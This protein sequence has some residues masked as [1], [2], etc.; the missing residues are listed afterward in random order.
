MNN[1]RGLFSV[2]VVVFGLLGSLWI[3][4]TAITDDRNALAQLAGYLAVG[5]FFVGL[6]FGRKALVL[7]LL[8]IAYG[9]LLKRGLV[10]FGSLSYYDIGKVLVTGPLVL[11]GICVN[12]LWA[13]ISGRIETRRFHWLVFIVCGVGAGLSAGYAMTF[14]SSAM[15]GLKNV[16]LGSSYLMLPWV[17]VMTLRTPDQIKRFLRTFLIIFFP[18]ALY[19]IKQ[20]L[21]GLSGFEYEY[22]ESGLTIESRQLVNEVMRVPSTMNAARSLSVTMALCLIIFIILRVCKSKSWSGVL[23]PLTFCVVPVYAL[24]MIFTLT[25]VG[26]VAALLF[27][28]LAV[29]F[30]GKVRTRLTYLFGIVSFGLLVAYSEPILEKW[31]D[32]NRTISGF[33]GADTAFERQA[34]SISTLSARLIGWRNLT[35]DTELWSAFGIK[36]SKLENMGNLNLNTGLQIDRMSSGLTHDVVTQSIV[37]FGMVPFFFVLVVVIVLLRWMHSLPFRLSDPEERRLAVLLLAG[38]MTIGLSGLSSGMHV[39]INA[40]LYMLVGML[41]SM[42]VLVGERK[43]FP[44]EA[45]QPAPHEG[46]QPVLQAGMSTT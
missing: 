23:H 28:F 43:R 9:D 4:V 19:G 33:V 11:A 1:S 42:A 12:L 17:I 30:A 40:L 5:S 2:L 36:E 37:K 8:L 14:Y 16:A 31:E 15:M 24:A 18:V 32:I 44:A 21:F 29:A 34:T 45:R 38:M 27:P 25:R 46:G 20:G 22:L 7:L 26:W 39:P 35:R 3:T 6:F 41:M 13:A 10:L